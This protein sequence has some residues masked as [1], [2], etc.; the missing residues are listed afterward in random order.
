MVTTSPG[1]VAVEMKGELLRG[2]D[3]VGMAVPDTN[4][5]GKKS[6]MDVSVPLRKVCRSSIH[7]QP[8]RPSSDPSRASVPGRAQGR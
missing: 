8:L 5:D 4:R 6:K 2:A 3:V 1:D 7:Q